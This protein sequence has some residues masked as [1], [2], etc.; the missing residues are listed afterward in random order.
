[1]TDM[2]S[3]SGVTVSPPSVTLYVTEP[4]ETGPTLTAG[5]VPLRAEWGVN[6]GMTTLTLRRQLGT[7]TG[8]GL[9][10]CDTAGAPPIGSLISVFIDEGATEEV[11]LFSGH[12]AQQ[13][14]MFQASPDSE[15]YILRAYGPELRLKHKAVHGQWHMTTA[16]DDDQVDGVDISADAIRA[17]AWA[18]HLPTVFNA[19][20]EASAYRWKEAGD[21]N[22]SQTDFKLTDSAAI[23]EAA[24]RVFEAPGRKVEEGSG[25]AVEA[26]YWTAYTAL[27]SLVEWFDNYETIS[28]DTDWATIEGYIGT[29]VIP[30]TDVDCMSLLDA[31]KAVLLPVGFGFCLEPWPD[32]ETYASGGTRHRLLVYPMHASESSGNPVKT[33]EAYDPTAGLDVGNIVYNSVSVQRFH[34]VRDAHNVANDI[35]V[36]GSLKRKLVLLQY[37]GVTAD[38]DL[39]PGWDE[40]AHDLADYVNADS[41]VSDT[42]DDFAWPT[43]GSG[44]T[45]PRDIWIDRFTKK[46]D[47]YD[48]YRHV[49]RRFSWNE[50]GQR[51]GAI[52]S[53]AN[54]GISDEALRRPRPLLPI[55][56]VNVGESI[57]PKVQIGIYGAS[58]TWVDCTAAD[59]DPTRCDITLTQDD[60]AKWYPWKDATEDVQDSYG[61]YNVAT[62]LYNS[63]Y[64]PTAQPKLAIR[65][66]GTIECDEAVNSTATR[67]AGT[68]WP[69]DAETSIRQAGRFAYIAVAPDSN[70][71]A[72]AESTRDDSTYIGT[73]TTAVQ[74]AMEDA[75]GH[76]SIV[77]RFFTTGFCP[78][79][80]IPSL[81]LR[82]TSMRLD[83]SGGTSMY[84]IVS[85]VVW[86]FADGAYKTEIMLDTNLL[87]VM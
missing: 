16:L 54:F 21:A 15:S 12:V 87:K 39:K 53:L 30:R 9:V 2:T 6:G 66:V 24:C 49:F 37:G 19:N 59:I 7:R 4:G 44:V 42:D 65:V 83:S 81:S 33:I 86:N 17:N 5:L 58:T 78:G 10:R 11:N 48:T 77:S 31:I 72:G 28:V 13:E 22:A 56:T 1:M 47:S 62:L 29:T 45:P 26:E 46:G 18:S 8:A 61:E 20:H 71:F 43:A 52:P 63:L 35:T 27:R 75:V 84:P 34:F 80:V 57:Q 38:L 60:L 25:Y 23:T 74:D 68:I 3:A 40:T 70:T 14:I 67:A 73:Y 32:G 41:Q 64:E 76:G 55:P 51:Y 85:G 79:D 82:G 50:D 36:L 69:S